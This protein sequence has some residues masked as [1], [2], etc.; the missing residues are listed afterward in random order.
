MSQDADF[1]FLFP[2]LHSRNRVPDLEALRTWYEAVSDALQFELPHDLFALWVYS[3]TGEPSL[4]AP[5]GRGG[6]GVRGLHPS[7]FLDPR[8]LARIED[9][10]Q[11]AHYGS[12]V[13]R[14]I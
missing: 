8:E 13:C 6:G 3:P 4:I 14:P 7:P 10:V 1:A 9:R 2:I 12:V 5:D 11:S